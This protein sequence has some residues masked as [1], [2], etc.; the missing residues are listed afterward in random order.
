[1]R[2]RG[3]RVPRR[4]ALT[5]L[6]RW[7]VIFLLRRRGPM[8]GR[9][10][11]EPVDHCRPTGVGQARAREVGHQADGAGPTRDRIERRHRSCRGR[12]RARAAVAP[13]S[14]VR[15]GDLGEQG[16]Q[17]TEQ[18]ILRVAGEVDMRFFLWRRRRGSWSGIFRRQGD[19][20]SSPSSMRGRVVPFG[21]TV[22][23]LPSPLFL[24]RLWAGRHLLHR[25]LFLVLARAC[26]PNTASFRYRPLPR[27]RSSRLR[28]RDAAHINAPPLLHFALRGRAAA[29][30]LALDCRRGPSHVGPV[31]KRRCRDASS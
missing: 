23:L 8:R 14:V 22:A 26:L 2:C 9:K 15:V 3:H 10:L 11:F 27:R 1:M 5:P 24:L 21:R 4:P 29:A 18:I 20:L 13:Q 30:G 19:P 28:R 6:H 25:L 31:S 17:E 7:P 12:V 16:S